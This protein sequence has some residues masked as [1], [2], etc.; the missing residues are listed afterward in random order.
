MDDVGV[1]VSFDTSTTK[2]YRYESYTDNADNKEL[3]ITLRDADGSATN[4]ITYETYTDNTSDKTITVTG[5][6]GMFL[7][8]M[9]GH[10][11]ND[12][13]KAIAD[14]IIEKIGL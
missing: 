3:T 12:G 5:L 7:S 1:I 4:T 6:E 14:R 8:W 9:G 10:P 13:M 2:S 11:N